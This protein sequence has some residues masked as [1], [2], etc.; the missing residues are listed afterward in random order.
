MAH[1]PAFLP[2]P[3][4]NNNQ[5]RF[6]CWQELLPEMKKEVIRHVPVLTHMSLSLCDKAHYSAFRYNMNRFQLTAWHIRGRL[7]V[8][9]TMGYLNA[10]WKSTCHTRE[11]KNQREQILRLMVFSLLMSSYYSLSGA[12][13]ERVQKT[14]RALMITLNA[15][16]DRLN[17]ETRGEYWSCRPQFSTMCQLNAPDEIYDVFLA[18]PPVECTITLLEHSFA[19]N[20]DLG[21]TLQLVLEH[22]WVDSFAWLDKNHK[23]INSTRP[24][25]LNFRLDKIES[26]WQPDHPFV[27]RF[28]DLYVRPSRDLYNCLSNYFIL[29]L[30]KR[31]IYG[32]LGGLMEWRFACLRG[33][34]RTA[35]IPLGNEEDWLLEWM[36]KP[37]GWVREGILSLIKALF[38]LPTL[39][40]DDDE[41]VMRTWCSDLDAL[42][43]LNNNF[44]IDWRSTPVPNDLYEKR[45]KAKCSLAYM[46]SCFQ[47]LIDA[48][49]VVD[50]DDDV[51]TNTLDTA[52]AEGE[53]EFVF[54]LLD[55]G[56]KVMQ[57][58]SP[59]D[60]FLAWYN[61]H[62]YQK[63]LDYRGF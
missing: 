6:V 58:D 32:S 45:D 30:V 4:D 15:W 42:Q 39:L 48:G 17:H 63:R 49:W 2:R 28:F 50:F 36:R 41:T 3:V 10:H 29:M 33:S 11:D 20:L 59:V 60:K 14:L 21:Y 35:P 57:K 24:N 22:R 7:T 56:W 1:S 62:A 54:W 38:T 19:P 44:Q 16:F 23:N 53:Y 34:T 55:R 52:F 26:W 9:D 43:N 5:A 25:F 61:G 37:A 27:L 18:S 51:E 47:F 40:L 13:A 8:E 12:R 31:G 46:K